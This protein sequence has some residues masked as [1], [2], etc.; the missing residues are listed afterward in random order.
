MS[1]SFGFGTIAK[2][3]DEIELAD[4][5]VRNGTLVSMGGNDGKI[6]D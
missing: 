3:I 1:L 6:R 5:A 2:A 4:G